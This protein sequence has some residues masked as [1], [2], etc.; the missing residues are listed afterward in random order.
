MQL[1]VPQHSEEIKVSFPAEHILLITLNR[2]KA[3]N[4]MTPDMDADID[5]I[6]T[7]VEDEP[8]IWY[9]PQIFRVL[10]HM[11]VSVQGFHHHRGRPSLLRRCRPH[12]VSTDPGHCLDQL[13]GPRTDGTSVR[14]LRRLLRASARMP[15]YTETASVPSRA[16]SPGASR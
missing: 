9:V 12:R 3:L 7:W 4:A 11:N 8:S 10:R 16:G 14:T 6:L 15:S 1:Q 5:R 13:T 2:P